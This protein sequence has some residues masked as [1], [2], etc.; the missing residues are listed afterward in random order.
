MR[1][2]PLARAGLIAGV[3][4]AATTGFAGLA[5]AHTVTV[6]APATA[7]ASPVAR[8]LSTPVTT[9][10]RARSVAA[11][12]ADTSPCSCCPLDMVCCLAGADCCRDCC[13]GAD[14][15]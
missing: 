8:T 9:E 11:F 7:S 10:A 5:Q 15:C 4:L 14:C 6:T 12:R 13:V 2:R 3:V 1:M